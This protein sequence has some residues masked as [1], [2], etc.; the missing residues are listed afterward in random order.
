MQHI[1][2]MRANPAARVSPARNPG[3]VLGFIA[4]ILLWGANWPVMKAGLA[5]VTPLWF[6]ALRFA[7]GAACLFALQVLRGRFHRP[8]RAD[9]P[10]IA[11][12]GL[13]QMAGFTAFGMLAMTVL[14]AGRSA[15]LSYTTPVW[16]APLAILLFRERVTKGRL[17]GIA[18]GILGVAVLVSPSAIA[19]SDPVVLGAN[20]LLLLAAA[21]WA[22]CILHLRH[23]RPTAGSTALAPWQMLL[24]AALL[25]VAAGHWEGSF[26]GDGTTGFWLAMLFVGPVATAFCF[27]MV[28]TASTRLPATS[29]SVS[30]LA[31]PLTGLLLS[32]LLLGERI[33]LSLALG[34]ACIAIGIT[35]TLLSR[36]PSTPIQQGSTACVRKS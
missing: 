24:A 30:M 14:P 11:S 25:A 8:R 16:V 13:L 17:V 2:A 22:F 29:M 32:V 33:D 6:S 5:H 35:V 20:A 19:W 23:G 3:W 36:A 10:L 28:N 31:V 9:L 4:A 21:C 1:A 26:T 12:I 34:T 7:A 15:I 27:V 18:L